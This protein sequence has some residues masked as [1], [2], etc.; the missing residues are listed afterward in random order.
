VPSWLQNVRLQPNETHAGRTIM[1][2]IGWLLN[3]SIFR[4]LLACVASVTAGLLTLSVLI[5]LFRLV[6]ESDEV[7][8]ELYVALSLG[9]VGSRILARRLIESIGRNAISFLRIELFQRIVTAP[10]ADIEQIGRSRLIMALTDDLGRIAGIVPNLVVLC[11]N[12]TLILAFLVYLAWLSVVQFGIIILVI[13][14]GLVCH[15]LLRREGTA[16]VRVSQQKRNDLLDVF[17][18]A[19]DSV[20]ELKLHSARREQAL[21]VFAERA[22]ELQASVERQSLYFGSSAMAAQILFYVALGLVMFGGFGE[23]VDRHL[24]VSYGV[25]ILYLMGP[26][27][28]SIQMVQELAAADITLDRV[29][30]L[31]LALDRAKV[32]QTIDNS[33]DGSCARAVDIDPKGFQQLQLSGVTYSY[34]SE[35]ENDGGGFVLGPIDLVLARGEV[36][37]VVGGNGSGKT[38]FVKVLAGLY[39]PTAGSIRVNGREITDG[40][41][42]PYC[43]LFSAVFHDFFV[44]E[45]FL[46]NSEKSNELLRRFDMT[47]R[48]E[49]KD[50][51]ITKPSSLSLGERKRLALMFAYLEDKPIVIF[52]EWAADQDPEFKELFYKKVLK[53]LSDLGKLVV[54]ISH[55]DRYFHLAD[56]L[57]RFNR[58]NP[59]PPQG[60][61]SVMLTA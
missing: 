38:T 54:V 10:L 8:L 37:F 49:I 52:D 20:K 4:F 21:E 42:E 36:V 15:F 22:K 25:A 48:V 19:L 1:R 17:R 47:G 43:Q 58:G 29:E 51:R 18:S 50:N 34:Q 55:D 27:R 59:S 30:E 57:L 32:R 28:G 41:S 26:L 3:E 9:A 11:A 14:V 33:G 60:G 44:F 6:G 56:K 24:T 53:E 45:R 35:V 39:P 31:G 61:G 2:V 46:E 13:V 5:L 16:Q 7:K 23:N 40:N 12:F